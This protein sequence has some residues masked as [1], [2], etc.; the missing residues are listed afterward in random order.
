MYF[1]KYIG[2]KIFVYIFKYILTNIY[3]YKIYIYMY[4]I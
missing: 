3:I 4:T 1:Q 2:R